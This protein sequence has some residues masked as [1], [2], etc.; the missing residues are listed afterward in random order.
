MV[1]KVLFTA[2][3]CLELL[4]ETL[5]VNPL[6][7]AGSNAVERKAPNTLLVSDFEVGVGS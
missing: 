5:A 7:M 6:T 1:I 4:A 3:G 2:G